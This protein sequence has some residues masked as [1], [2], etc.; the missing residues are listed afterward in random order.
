[1]HF[2]I[3]AAMCAA[4]TSPADTCEMQYLAC[5]RL[6]QALRPARQ[7]GTYVDL[8]V[9]QRALNWAETCGVWSRITTLGR[10]RSRVEIIWAESPKDLH[11]VLAAEIERLC[12][13]DPTLVERERTRQRGF[14]A[15]RAAMT[16][17]GVAR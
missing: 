1:M 16:A 5:C 11:R 4:N 9:R 17:E 8:H 12:Q 3:E 13:L 7:G 15:A 14:Y 6:Q 2:I 10:D